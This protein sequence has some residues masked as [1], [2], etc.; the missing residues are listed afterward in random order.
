MSAAAASLRKVNENFSGHGTVRAE[1]F[2]HTIIRA[3]DGPLFCSWKGRTGLERVKIT[4]AMA[5]LARSE[6]YG[7]GHYSGPYIPLCFRGVSTMFPR[8]P[9]EAV[10]LKS[11]SLICSLFSGWIRSGASLPLFVISRSPVRLRRVTPILVANSFE[12]SPYLDYQPTLGKRVA[13]FLFHELIFIWI[14]FKT[15]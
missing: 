4:L 1:N 9:A 3:G 2:N 6:R 7:L 13:E 5:N 10:K 12:Y 14:G 8:N 11:T 15:Y